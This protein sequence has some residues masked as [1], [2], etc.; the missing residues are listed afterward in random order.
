M[1]FEVITAAERGGAPRLASEPRCKI[2]NRQTG[3]FRRGGAPKTTTTGT[4]AEHR[5]DHEKRC[6]LSLAMV[7]LRRLPIRLSTTL[8][9]DHHHQ[10]AV[11]SE[12]FS[13]GGAME[14]SQ[15]KA[16]QQID[17]S[18]KVGDFGVVLIKDGPGAGMLGYYAYDEGGGSTVCCIDYQGALEVV[19]GVRTSDMRKVRPELAR[20]WFLKNHVV[21]SLGMV[22]EIGWKLRPEEEWPGH[23]KVRLYEW[24]VVR[25]ARGWSIGRLGFY[26]D[27]E[28][29]DDGHA[30]AIVYATDM[31]TADGYWMI[32]RRDLRIPTPAQAR[33]WLAKHMPADNKMTR[34]HLRP[35]EQ[36][37]KEQ[38]ARER[39]ANLTLV[40][41]GKE[42]PEE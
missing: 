1:A 32:S 13:G 3:S 11:G 40:D 12:P 42:P 5:S 18:V 29:D 19:Y 7:G 28:H 41:G 37:T 24:G 30:K 39:R 34:W 17:T 23:R 33:R 9:L 35:A 22:D 8:V 27:D 16:G 15:R 6:D 38:K 10:L 25:I 36:L 14:A 31:S 21:A 26:D 2:V 4:G 20:K